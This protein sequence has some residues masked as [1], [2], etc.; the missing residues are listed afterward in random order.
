MRILWRRWE[1][2]RAELEGMV[3]GEREAGHDRK[4]RDNAHVEDEQRKQGRLEL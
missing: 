4:I 2:K 1:G 3:A